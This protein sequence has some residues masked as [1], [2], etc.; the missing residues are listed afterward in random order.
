MSI[1]I[2]FC[3]F[4]EKTYLKSKTSSHLFY[5]SSKFIDISQVRYNMI[6][7]IVLKN[8]NQDIVQLELCKR[9]KIK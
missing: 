2:H 9:K 6:K 8:R 1:N 4:R 7:Q 3:I 5:E